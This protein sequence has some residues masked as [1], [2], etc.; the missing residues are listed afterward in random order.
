MTEDSLPKDLETANSAAAVRDDPVQMYL[1]DIGTIDLLKVNQEFWLG[2]RLLSTRRLDAIRREH[3]LMR[4]GEQSL[5]NLF[6]AIYDEV[7][8]AWERI[9]EDVARLELDCPD[10]IAIIEE[11]LGLRKTWDLESPSYIRDYLNNGLWGGDNDWGVVA[12]NVFTIAIA[13]YIFPEEVSGWIKE[14]IV[15]TDGNFPPQEEFMKCLPGEAALQLEIDDVW[16]RYY[17]G[18]SA[19]IRANLRLVVSVAKRYIGR[20]NSFL[21]LI[22]EGNLGLLRAVAK[23]DPMRGYKFS[24]YA[25]WWIRQSVSRSI[26]D[27][28]R[29]IRIPVHVFETVTLLLRIRRHLV[30]ELEYEP[31]PEDIVLETDY[32]DPEDKKIIRRHRREGTTLPAGVHLRWREAA[33]KAASYLR[34]AEDP[35]S[36]DH[37]LNGEEDNSLKDFIEDKEALE[38][39]EETVQEM[40]RA[41]L[42]KTLNDLPPRE[43]QVLELR[44][45][46]RDGRIH[47]LEEVGVYFDVT[48][49]RIRQIEAKA[50]RKLRNPAMS[51]KLGEFL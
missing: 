25:T 23:F 4:N 40:M 34:A 16:S 3:P 32:L 37:P 15:D 11:S 41:Q 20:G 42:Q 8:V 50:L 31:M 18:Y 43:R 51:K 14:Y 19:I 33:N 27:Q 9:Q 35:M 17:E 5:K 48:R 30:Q 47:T 22:Q 1:N 36:L 39:L 10:L 7:V 45:G 46:L 2:I 49:E 28:A 12:R 29:T 21:D 38:P 13:F 44:F 26:A 6:C 24:T